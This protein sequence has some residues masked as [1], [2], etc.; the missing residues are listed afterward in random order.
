LHAERQQ[1]Q[2]QPRSRRSSWAP[3]PTAASAAEPTPQARIHTWAAASA[4]AGEAV[5]A[6][7][8]GAWGCQRLGR[9]ASPGRRCA[10]PLATLRRRMSLG[11]EGSDR[12]SA[13]SWRAGTW[14][15]SSA[16]TWGRTRAR[17][18]L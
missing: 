12:C 3:D 15:P 10:R 16:W 5:G 2:Q 1:Q 11:K 17:R 4:T 13:A 6:A 14:W 8:R 9:T 7:A 18:S